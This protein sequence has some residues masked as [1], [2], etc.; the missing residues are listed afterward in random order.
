MLASVRPP[1]PSR[2]FRKLKKAISRVGRAM[3]LAPQRENESNAAAAAIV[4]TL[5]TPIV[6]SA[7]H[8][9]CA[10]LQ[11]AWDEACKFFEGAIVLSP[12]SPMAEALNRQKLDPQCIDEASSFVIGGKVSDDVVR[13]IKARARNASAMARKLIE[14]AAH[15]PGALICYARLEKA[16]RFPQTYG[17]LGD[18]RLGEK[19]A[20]CFGFE[21]KTPA[22]AQRKQT[23][24]HDYQGPDDFVVELQTGEPDDMLILARTPEVAP[25]L[26]DA[27]T[28]VT[29]RLVWKPKPCG[30]GDVLVVPCIFLSGLAAFEELQ[31]RRVVAEERWILS[32]AVQ[33]IRFALDEEGVTLKSFSLASFARSLGP[34]VNHDMVLKPPF[35]AIM[36]RRNAE[37]PYFAFW[38]GNHDFLLRE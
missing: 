33:S 12:P 19:N 27:V 38:V 35:L 20:P 28:Q 36:K 7:N 5:E 26:Q 34:L 31:G 37:T 22:D 6:A 25:T 11:L 10:T 23:L 9:W 4:P 3:H 16:L 32:Q 1:S 13:K 8:I 29:Q 18:Y 15:M 21:T 24:V 2:T 30:K 14:Q 17:S